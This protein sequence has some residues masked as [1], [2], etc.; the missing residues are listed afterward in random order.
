MPVHHGAAFIGSALASVAAEAPDG[1]EVRI[2]N[3]A[4]DGGAAL[5]VAEGFTDQ[6]QI[7]WQDRPDLKPWTSKT[8]LG[9]AEAHT[10]YI[11]MLHQDDLWLPGHLTA[12]RQAVDDYPDTTM[13]IGASHFAGPDGRLLSEW[14][15]PFTP[16]PHS[17]SDLSDALLVQ[18]TVAI[19]SPVIMKDAWLACGGMDEALWYTAD[20]D[21]YLKLARL[22]TVAVRPDS[23]TAF[24]LHGGSLT[25]AGRED[26]HEFRYQLETVLQRHLVGDEQ[27]RRGIQQ[28]AQASIAVNCALAAASSGKLGELPKA[29]LTLAKLGPVGLASYIARSRIIDRLRPRLRLRLAG[30]L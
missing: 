20:W 11:A 12:V 24:R 8:N 21:L 15:L 5:R 30:G 17:G 4:D 29:I 7:V 1:V 9:V 22:G 10:P 18:N 14:R 2:Y 16:G 26:M 13:S 6:L 19:P 25:M 27:L 23:T 28:Q 3:S